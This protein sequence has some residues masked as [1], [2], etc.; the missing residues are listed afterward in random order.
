[1][2]N[3]DLANFYADSFRKQF[4]QDVL[5]K[6]K[7]YFDLLEKENKKRDEIREKESDELFK[8]MSKNK[9]NAE[10][11]ETAPKTGTPQTEGKDLNKSDVSTAT[12]TA[13][14]GKVSKPAKRNL[15]KWI[16]GPF[17][18]LGA[19]TGFFLLMKYRSSFRK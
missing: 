3:I 16:F 10:N 12:T 11:K 1:M 19:A 5:N 18:F 15:M 13:G 14:D 2:Q 6:Y 8:K 17:L 7:E 4:G 9:K